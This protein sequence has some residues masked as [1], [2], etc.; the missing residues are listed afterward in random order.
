MVFVFIKCFNYSTKIDYTEEF[1]T[2]IRTEKYRTRVMNSAIIPPFCR[3]YN[4]DIGCFNGKKITPRNIS[5][6]NT[7]LFIYKNHSFL[8]WKPNDVSFVQAI[9]ELKRNFKV[10]DTVIS[11]KNDENFIK[12]DHKLKKVLSPLSNMVNYDVET[13][14]TI[15]G[16]PYANC[17]YK[18]S[19]ISGR[20]HWDIIEK[21][22]QKCFIDCIVF[23][24]L[25]KLNEMLHYVLQF[26]RES[27]KVKTKIVENNLYLIAQKESGFYS[28]F[29]LNK[30]LQWR[31]VVN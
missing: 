31:S 23:E 27:K 25:D 6:R 24:G 12:N 19:K 21:E 4:I 22:D 1:L 30:L 2:S 29:V 9:K 14:N 17:K 18:L 26:K 8:I 10:V 16:V 3:K 11:D 15:K 20:Y 7:S 13:F 28:Y 5:Q